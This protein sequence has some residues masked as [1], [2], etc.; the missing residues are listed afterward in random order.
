M[1]RLKHL[2]YSD[3]SRQLELE[4]RSEQQPAFLTLMFRILH[5][6][7]LP[8]LLC[9]AA[10][11]AM[12]CRIPAVPQFLT[13]LNLVLFGIEISPRCEIGPGVFFPHT[14]GTVIGAYSIGTNVTIFQGVTLGAKSLDMKFDPSMRPRIGDNVTLG[15]GCK[16]LGGIDIGENAVVGANAVVV[17]SVPADSVAT[18]IPA[19]AK[20]SGCKENYE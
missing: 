5:P 11:Q 15:S 4:G 8:V 14:Y 3:L 20:N 1:P 7:F 2:L 18:G 6:R 17:R 12:L 10:R 19:R 13:Y 16:V 9:R